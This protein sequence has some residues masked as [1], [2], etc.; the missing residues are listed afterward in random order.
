MRRAYEFAAIA[1]GIGCMLLAGS[2]VLVTRWTWPLLVIGATI[3][4]LAAWLTSQAA[5]DRRAELNTNRV[6][7]AIDATGRASRTAI[8]SLTTST[9]RLL[10]DVV[11]RIDRVRRDIEDALTA[12]MPD[13]PQHPDDAQDWRPA[14]RPAEP[15]EPAEPADDPDPPTTTFPAVTDPSHAAAGTAAPAAAD[16]PPDPPDPGDPLDPTW[17]WTPAAP[18][19]VAGDTPDPAS[20]GWQADRRSIDDD[21]IAGWVGPGWDR[22]EQGGRR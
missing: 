1:A 22:Q 20:I 3:V 4:A 6:L 21:E 13:T 15:A 12:P 8:E 2:G 19:P 7:Q 17:T 9:E 14:D 10:G 18:G 11:A 16:Q 5:A